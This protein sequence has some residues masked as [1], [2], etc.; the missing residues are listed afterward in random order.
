MNVFFA[1]FLY[2]IIALTLALVFCRNFR[3][4]AARRDPFIVCRSCAS[5]N[6]CH[7]PHNATV[8]PSVEVEDEVRAVLDGIP[9]FKDI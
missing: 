9:Q 1:F 3:R 7:V 2:I 4:Q 6:E 5:R 8:C